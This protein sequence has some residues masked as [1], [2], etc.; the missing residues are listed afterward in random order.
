MPLLPANLGEIPVEILEKMKRKEREEEK[1]MQG[2]IRNL[3]IRRS[4]D[5]REMLRENMQP[6]CKKRRTGTE[7]FKRVVKTDGE[8]EKR[9][10]ETE[11]SEKIM[12]KE[13]TGNKLTQERMATDKAVQ[14]SNRRKRR[15]MAKVK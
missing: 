14:R 15:E 5:R 3:K 6:A 8:S 12:R 1:E 4:K 9:T 13:M 11:K 2:K 7:T 10:L